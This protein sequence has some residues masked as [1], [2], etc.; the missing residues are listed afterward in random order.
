[1]LHDHAVALLKMNGAEIVDGGDFDWKATINGHILQWRKD[2]PLKLPTGPLKVKWLVQFLPPGQYGCSMPLTWDLGLTDEQK[3]KTFIEYAKCV[4]WLTK[5]VYMEFGPDAT[6]PNL[7]LSLR[8]CPIG[9]KD[10]LVRDFSTAAVM[11]AE[12]LIAGRIK[13]ETLARW[14][15]KNSGLT[16]TAD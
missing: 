4:H 7:D 15:K 9:W 13:P 1:M 5:T 6:H 12:N 8:G 14:M 11:S 3:V 2:I 10:K 16:G